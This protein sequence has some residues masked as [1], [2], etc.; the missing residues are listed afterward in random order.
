LA[1]SRTATVVLTAVF[2]G[3]PAINSDLWWKATH[4][5]GYGLGWA[6][7]ILLVTDRWHR[8]PLGAALSALATWAID[9]DTSTTIC[10]S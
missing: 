10:A 8:V 5:S 7:A 1:P 3:V 2:G 9:L 6:I 4:L